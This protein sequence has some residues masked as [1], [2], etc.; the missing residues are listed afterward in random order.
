[1]QQKLTNFIKILKNIN[2][3]CIT[4]RAKMFGYSH[5]IYCLQEESIHFDLMVSANF[6][7]ETSRHFST[8]NYTRKFDK[9]LKLLYIVFCPKS[10]RYLQVIH[11]RYVLVFICKNW[12]Y[13]FF[14]S[15]GMHPFNHLVGCFSTD[16]DSLLI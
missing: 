4:F 6:G 13:Y 14:S 12:F 16:I 5:C 11:F 2:S 15:S 9:T 7:L 1:M 8:K 10:F 3:S